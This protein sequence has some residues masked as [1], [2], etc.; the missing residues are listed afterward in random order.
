MMAR[1]LGVLTLL[2]FCSSF[3]AGQDTPTP[4]DDRNNVPFSTLFYKLGTNTLNSFTYGYGVP[5]LL[6][7]L[8]TYYFV[9]SG[10]DWEWSTIAVEHKALAFSGTPFGALGFILPAAMPLGLYL[11]GRSGQRADLQITGL[12]LGQAAILG[13]VISSSIKAFT[14]RRDPGI[15][16]NERDS[17]DFSGDFAF[18]FMERG[19]FSGWPSSHTAVIFAMAVTLAELYPK[20]TGL[21][22]AAY[23]YAALTGIGMSLFAH[24]ASDAVAGALVGYAIGK[25]V[26][27]SYRELLDRNGGLNSS[28]NPASNGANT[29]PGFEVTER[30]SVTI[31]PRYVG[32]SVRY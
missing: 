31:L 4:G 26:G 25:S 30:V 9:H 6:A 19:V 28:G 24:W 21:K 1:F 10:L 13:V 23:S 14:G 12:A 8:G 5:Y 22:I 16:N 11:Y 20:N 7:G 3:A 18:G 15:I 17:A 27:K 32:I 2:I 29:M